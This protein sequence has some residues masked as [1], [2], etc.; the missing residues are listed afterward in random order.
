M[1]ETN[2]SDIILS[3]E[4]DAQ[5]VPDKIFWHATAGADNTPSE[6]KAVL[7]SIF[8]KDHRDTLKF[9]IWTKEMQ[10]QEMDRMVYYTLKGLCDSYLRATGNK[11]L[12]SDMQQFVA[13]FGLKTEI[14]K[15]EDI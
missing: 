7:L 13:H 1:S 11:E 14:L 10:V 4:L 12:A 15:K 6:A 9:D 3:V 8:D 5:K 2:K